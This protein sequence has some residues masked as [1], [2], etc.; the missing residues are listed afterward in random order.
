MNESLEFHYKEMVRLA[1]VFDSHSKDAFNDFKLLGAV[2]ALLSWG[3]LSSSFEQIQP[4][5]MLLGFLAILAVTGLV[6]LFALMRQSVVNYQI[7]ELKFFET[8][9][10]Q[11]LSG[12]ELETFRVAEHWLAWAKTRQRR[13][14][15]HFYFLFYFVILAVPCVA[16]YPNWIYMGIYVVVALVVIALH[17]RA[18]SIVYPKEDIA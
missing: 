1:A 17:F 15:Q 4:K 16:L 14:G 12:S 18:L 5:T 8:Q 3:P 13:L 11:C 7:K 9:I 10:R 6:G 2:G